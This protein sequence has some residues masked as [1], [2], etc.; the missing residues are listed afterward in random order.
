MMAKVKAF[1]KVKKILL[2]TLPKVNHYLNVIKMS[3]LET[4]YFFQL[5]AST[6]YCSI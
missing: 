4:V 1:L 3:H 5:Q 2:I 6:N